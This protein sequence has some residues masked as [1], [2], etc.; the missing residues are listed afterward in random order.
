MT[1]VVERA[2]RHRDLRH[3]LAGR[4]IE[5][6]GRAER[7]SCRGP[8]ED[9]ARF[10]GP[11]DPIRGVRQLAQ[12]RGRAPR[13][14]IEA[15]LGNRADRRPQGF[16]QIDRRFARARAGQPQDDLSG[17]DILARLGKGLDDRP[18]SIRRKRRICPFVPRHLELRF[19]GDQQ[20]P[21]AVRA[22]FRLIVGGFRD[23]ARG[24]QCGMARRIGCGLEV[25][26]PGR[27]DIARLCGGGVRIIGA[28]DPHQRLARPNRLAR[29]DQP[30][31]DL[32]R[33][34]EAEVAL[35]SG[36]NHAGEAAR[37][38]VGRLHLGDLDSL[39]FGSRVL[40][41]R[42]LAAGYAGRA[43]DKG[44]EAQ[45]FHPGDRG[46]GKAHE[47]HPPPSALKD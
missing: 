23:R 27:G 19:G 14:P 16:G 8:V 10:I 11:R 43:Q 15:G 46:I 33:H 6:R 2:E 47:D 4:K 17:G 1:L 29:V 7:S 44:E 18:V 13:H 39:D 40:R 45:Y 38:G 30:L 3:R 32:A 24:N 5:R 41:H 31:S 25:A 9:I 22:R 35:H 42:R 37:A 26:R 28:V 36:G 20:R 34:P 12:P 21:G